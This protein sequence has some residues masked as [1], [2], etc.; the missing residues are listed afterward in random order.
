LSS[1]KIFRLGFR[2]AE[3][4]RWKKATATCNVRPL[5][6]RFSEDDVVLDAGCGVGIELNAVSTRVKYSVGLDIDLSNLRIARH[7][8]GDRA[9]K[10]DFIRADICYLPF[11]TSSFSKILCFDVLYGYLTN[12]DSRRIPSYDRFKAKTL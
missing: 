12:G 2:F 10:I 1:N 4:K 9:Q 6:N 7:F 5:L 3:S 8:L 11:R